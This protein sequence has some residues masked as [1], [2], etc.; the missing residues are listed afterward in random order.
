MDNTNNNRDQ[1][2][3]ESSEWQNNPLQEEVRLIQTHLTDI[4]EVMS[5]ESD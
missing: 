3:S 4:L 2:A 5:Q 1:S